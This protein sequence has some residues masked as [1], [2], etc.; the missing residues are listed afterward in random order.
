MSVNWETLRTYEEWADALKNLLN[1]A[2]IALETNDLAAR[3]R[4]K[5]D[6]IDFID[7]SPNWLIRNLDD[8]AHEAIMDLGKATI[9]EAITGIEQ[10]TIDLIRLTK[11]IQS[12]AQNAQTSAISLRLEK[13]IAAIDSSTKAVKAINDLRNEL[14]S[15]G[16]DKKVETLATNAIKSIQELRTALELD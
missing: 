8:V 14:A 7:E 6:L 16:K 15:T 9:T 4:V 3:G 2:R 10:R 1:A 12:I 11:S 13:S 5:R